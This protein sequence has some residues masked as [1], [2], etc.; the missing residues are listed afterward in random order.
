MRYITFTIKALENLKI[1]G[2]G[3]Q[4]DD[5]NS[6]DYIPGSSLRG[7]IIRNYI[8]AHQGIDISEDE[9]SRQLFLEGDIIFYNAYILKNNEETVPFPLCF[10]AP[11]DTLKQYDG[12]A[13]LA[14][15]INELKDTI[16]EDYKKIKLGT[17][18]KWN[19]EKGSLAYTNVDKVGNLHIT[20]VREENNLFRYE[21]IKAGQFF[22]GIL[23]IKQEDKVEEIK[24]LLENKILYLGGAKGSGYGKCEIVELVVTEE[25]GKE[26]ALV[27]ENSKELYLVVLS[28]TLYT[29]EYGQ[30]M[31]IIEADYIER[32]LGIEKVELTQCITET[33]IISGYNAK[34]GT[35][36]PQYKGIKAGSVFKYTVQ[37][38][39]LD[40]NKVKAL[41]E[42]GIGLRTQEGF[43]RIALLSEF[44]IECICKI[45]SVK[46][47][48]Y[49][50]PILKNEEMQTVRYMLENIYERKFAKAIDHYL[51]EMVHQIKMNKSTKNNQ[52]GNL[53]NLVRELKVLSATGGKERFSRYMEHLEDKST[54]AKNQLKDIFIK[55]E[56]F[57]DYIKELMNHSDDLK[58]FNEQVFELP[59]L[60]IGEIGITLDREKVHQHTLLFMERLL[61]YV[62]RIRGHREG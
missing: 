20:K 4:I 42:K 48:T 15:I 43:G 2:S 30:S 21:A 25:Y 45:E 12:T 9:V 16:E 56:R 10:Y 3:K 31:G 24:K 49:A 41:V 8:N 38:G 1:G 34:W 54:G 35:K 5:E 23:G 36:L 52:L 37:T 29:N 59:Q 61:R 44:N 11:K 22:K 39:H 13:N 51:F 28:D 27:E 47:E 55:N 46:E 7:A 19:L 58:F 17:F 50:L 14:P 62:I 6:L 26:Y 57:I 40:T 60:V 18:C 32:V 53:L 33:T